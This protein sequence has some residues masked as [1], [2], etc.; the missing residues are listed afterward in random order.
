MPAASAAA[1]PVAI[2]ALSPAILSLVKACLEL[3]LH[4]QASA[5]SIIS[6]DEAVLLLES[7]LAALQPQV[8]AP[9]GVRRAVRP[10]WRL[11]LNNSA[12]RSRCF[13]SPRGAVSA[14]PLRSC[15][16]R[17]PLTSPSTEM[18]RLHCQAFARCSIHPRS[19]KL[20]NDDA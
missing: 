16:R 2:A 6:S 4:V 19:L 10:S 9:R 15:S 12:L 17:R 20:M 7:S 11:G 1:Q 14:L 18:S 13:A 3:L 5:S 8:G